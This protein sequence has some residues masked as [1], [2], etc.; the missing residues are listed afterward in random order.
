MLRQARA[1]RARGETDLA[2]SAAE[3]ALVF[4]K[5]SSLRGDVEQFLAPLGEATRAIKDRWA[6]PGWA[7]MVQILPL[8]VIVAAAA[9][10]FVTP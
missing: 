10:R 4:A 6:K 2:R 5:N 8:A 1:F 9:S 3:Q 7:P